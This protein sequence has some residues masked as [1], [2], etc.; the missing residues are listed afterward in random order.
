VISGRAENVQ[1]VERLID[2]LGDDPATWLP[3]FRRER[4][5]K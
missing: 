3:V 4:E 1:R 2:E 5:S